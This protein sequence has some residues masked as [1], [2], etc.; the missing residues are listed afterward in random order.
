MIQRL[1]DYM[2]EFR[3]HTAFQRVMRNPTRH[4]NEAFR[5]L[6][7][8]RSPQQVARMERRMGIM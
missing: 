3:I 2:H 4:N 7:L 6:I 5:Q 8:D 1:K